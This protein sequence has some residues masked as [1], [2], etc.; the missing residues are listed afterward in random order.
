MARDRGESQLV[1][2][3][4]IAFI[5]T[6]SVFFSWKGFHKI[7]AIKRIPQ[8]DLKKSLWGIIDAQIDMLTF[9]GTLIVIILIIR[10]PGLIA[11]LRTGHLSFRPY[12]RDQ[13]LLSFADWLVAPFF[14]LIIIFPWRISHLRSQWKAKHPDFWFHRKLI[15]KTACEVIVDVPFFALC[16]PIILTLWRVGELKRAFASND[17]DGRRTQCYIQFMEW[18]YDIPA[19]LAGTLVTLTIYRA[20]SMWPQVWQT[21]EWISKRKMVQEQGLCLLLDLPALL[22]LS[23]LAL[24][25]RYIAS[26]MTALKSKKGVQCHYHI[27]GAIGTCMSD[28]LHYD[29][30]SVFYCLVTFVLFWRMPMMMSV[31][32]EARNHPSDIRFKLR[33]PK[34]KKCALTATTDLPA[35][36]SHFFI[37][38]TMWNTSNLHR[39]LMNESDP[40]RRNLVKMKMMVSTIFRL[41]AILGCALVG[42]SWRHRQLLR[43][44]D[45]ISASE[46][47]AS[48]AGEMSM[49]D[50][51][52]ASVVMTLLK[53]V[54]FDIVTI[55]PLILCLVTLWRTQPT[56]S[57]FKKSP[58]TKEKK[59]DDVP[60]QDELNMDIHRAIWKQFLYLM[61]DVL[62]F[63]LVAMLIIFPWRGYLWYLKLYRI[64]NLSFFPKRQQFVKQ[65]LLAPTDPISLLILTLTLLSWRG[66]NFYRVLK[67]VASTPTDPPTSGIRRIRVQTLTNLGILGRD[68]PY[69]LMSPMLLWRL[70]YVVTILMREDREP[71]SQRNFV[72]NQVCETFLDV[73]HVL[74]LFVVLVTGYRVRKLVEFSKKNFDSAK[75]RA[76]IFR[77]FL[78]VLW[79]AI[80]LIML[81]VL[82]ATV[83]RL[84]SLERKWK[85]QKELKLR[86]KA[87]L[88]EKIQ[89]EK[90]DEEVPK[91]RDVEFREI[92]WEEFWEWVKDTPYIVLLLLQPWRGPILIFR[93]LKLDMNDNLRRELISRQFRETLLDLP[94]LPSFFLISVTVYRLP[95]TIKMIHSIIGLKDKEMRSQ[96]LVYSVRV[97]MDLLALIQTLLISI[98][99]WRAGR[100]WKRFFQVEN[101]EENAIK[102]YSPRHEVVFDEFS[103]WL[104]DLPYIF[105]L[106]FILILNPYRSLHILSHFSE[107]EDQDRRN[108]IGDALL[109]V[110]ADYVC[111]LMALI[112]AVTFWRVK[113]LYAQFQLE[114]RVV[115]GARKRFEFWNQRHAI[116]FRQFKQWMKDVPYLPG[117][118]FIFLTVYRIPEFLSAIWNQTTD[119]GRRQEVVK[120]AKIIVLHTL[121]LIMA[122]IITITLWRFSALVVQLHKDPRRQTIFREFLLLMNDMRQFFNLIVILTFIMHVPSFF[123]RVHSIYIQHKS[124]NRKFDE[125]YW[126]ILG[127]V[128]KMKKKVKVENQVE[129]QVEYWNDMPN[130]IKRE[131]AQFLDARGL[132]KLAQ[133]NKKCRVLADDW[134]LWSKLQCSQPRPSQSIHPKEWYKNVALSQELSQAKKDYMLGVRFVVQD[135]YQK[136]L[137]D[138]HHTLLLPAKFLA[139]FLTFSGTIYCSYVPNFSGCVVLASQVLGP[140][141]MTIWTAHKYF[142]VGLGTTIL[143]ILDI[144]LN[145]FGIPV[146]VSM[147]V[148]HHSMGWIPTQFLKRLLSYTHLL[149]IPMGIVYLFFVASVPTLLW[150]DVFTSLRNS[151]E[152][153]LEFLRW[154]LIL[155]NIFWIIIP[156]L[157]PHTVNQ[158]RIKKFPLFDPIH[159]WALVGNSTWK[160]AVKVSD[161]VH[162]ISVEI[163]ARLYT[164][165]LKL[166]SGFK[167]ALG[168]LG[169]RL[170]KILNF[171][172]TVMIKFLRIFLKISNANSRILAYATKTC[173]SMGTLGEILLIPIAFLWILWPVGFAFFWKSFSA[174]VPAAI[175]SSY[176]LRRAWGVIEGSWGDNHTVNEEP[177]FKA[178]SI[179][180]ESPAFEGHGIQIRIS[181]KKPENF[182]LKEARLSIEGDKFWDVLSSALGSAVVAGF[183]F[184][185]HPVSLCPD[186]LNP[187]DFLAG[188]EN[189]TFEIKFGT[190]EN[191]SRIK[192]K[193]VTFLNALTTIIDK[194]DPPMDL[195][196]E[197]GTTSFMWKKLGN[198]IRIKTKASSIR[199]AIQHRNDLLEAVQ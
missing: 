67:L 133:V 95:A 46:K 163:A 182:T 158:A 114:N 12:L 83:W 168:F 121:H 194:G 57:L 43:K 58:S 61:V 144:I 76:E 8:F 132:C 162:R 141:N 108:K 103:Q 24:Q 84:P 195:V 152:I 94:Y 174:A 2:W 146:Y 70:P 92:V 150:N 130:D 86:K 124:R 123:N 186:Y 148:A 7:P 193:D 40:L 149:G 173:Q 18:L 172:T 36:I 89:L 190:G 160:A 191:G 183:K 198:V 99:F 52:R 54:S 44:F 49:W 179:Y 189:T 69:V 77:N 91:S 175:F 11:Y 80:T 112:I 151:T 192:F 88:A 33:T 78:E 181:G 117:V 65:C 25:G 55:V 27:F 50:D 72:W 6:L 118:L 127:L 10:I 106:G 56:L 107:L 171:V 9:M 96:I 66:V 23:L 135:E 87:E 4:S 197:Y 165:I 20:I 119:K 153:S 100:F 30:P 16:I 85:V 156:A 39:S 45:E 64:S 145:F 51:Y 71:K 126:I 184:S 22:C 159:P 62:L 170:L 37:V 41:P 188:N 79:D 42:V 38:I 90:A 82:F 125:N 68:L 63:P 147:A 137:Q 102:W 134:D 35:C 140:L 19:F 13:L 47:L 105:Q 120:Q 161:M 143:I 136:S 98:T 116:V 166:A 122:I 21:Q 164:F 115:F 142:F 104:L 101:I 110:F 93:R 131:V 75:I 178:T 97:G 14:I 177:I 5:T 74:P 157:L 155:I 128:F 28:M 34:L 180:V 111:L 29:V 185:F 199:D 48:T 138:W 3:I 113:F 73:P 196:L 169:K 60:R 154:K 1:L 139:I 109:L 176:L 26:V 187:A 167:L 81:L 31:F 59:D 129:N 53:M 32:R 15:I 17:A